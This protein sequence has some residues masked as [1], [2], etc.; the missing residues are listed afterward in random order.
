MISYSNAIEVT[1]NA[2]YWCQSQARRKVGG[3]CRSP[4]VVKHYKLTYRSLS[5]P[6]EFFWLVQQNIVKKHWKETLE[7]S[8]LKSQHAPVILN[9]GGACMRL[10]LNTTKTELIWFDRQD[11]SD[12][13][14]SLKIL[15][16]DSSCSIPPSEV[17][18]YLGVLLDCNLNTT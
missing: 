5:L 7:T 9:P 4:N 13:I 10:K 3:G 11:Q 12:E 1:S 17:V 15:K 6:S 16:L 8:K 14:K 2:Q 18:R